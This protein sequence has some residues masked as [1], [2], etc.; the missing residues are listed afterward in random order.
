[1]FRPMCS[2]LP[3]E[4]GCF[5]WEGDCWKIRGITR[6]GGGGGRGV[7]GVGVK[8]GK[9]QLEKWQLQA[10]EGLMMWHNIWWAAKQLMPWQP[11]DLWNETLTKVHI[12]GN[13]VWNPGLKFLSTHQMENCRS[14]PTEGMPPSK[15]GIYTYFA[16]LFYIGRSPIVLVTQLHQ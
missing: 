14:G 12:S 6:A 11:S 2:S 5:K 4:H 13:R 1:M 9:V 16:M 10:R 3:L 15:H 8:H 7:A